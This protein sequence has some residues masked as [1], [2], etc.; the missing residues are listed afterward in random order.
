MKN[1]KLATFFSIIMGILPIV[2]FAKSLIIDKDQTISS[3]SYNW[4]GH[5]MGLNAGAVKH[6]MNITDNQAVTFNATIQEVTDPGFTEGFQLGYRR[7]LNQTQTSGVFGLEFSANFSDAKSHK[8]YGSPFA[9]Y[10]L[11]SEHELKNVMLAELIAGIA[12]DRSLLFMAAGLSWFTISGNVINEDG[13]PFFN[14][15]TVGKKALAAAVG[16]GIEYAVSENISA[17]VKVD[18]L[19]P[20]SYFTIDNSND[21]YGIANNIAQGT[22]GVNYRFS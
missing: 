18:V 22:I 7:Q 14:E 8:T 12:A 20:Q 5:Y 2:T 15:Y 19:V 16:G 6:V 17:R 13:I 3:V 11:R 9:L 4:T 1:F 21:T 10:Q